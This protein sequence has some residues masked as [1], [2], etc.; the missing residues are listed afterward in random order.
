M[1]DFDYGRFCDRLTATGRRRRPRAYGKTD[2]GRIATPSGPLI[3]FASN[4]YLGLSRHPDVI[5][6]AQEFASRWGT[7]AAASRLVCGTL[8]IHEAIEEKVARGKGAEAALVFASGYQANVSV[9][10][11]LLDA[12][13]LGGEPLVLSDRLNHASIHDGCRLAGAREVRYRHNDLAHLDELLRTH[14]RADQPCFI[15]SETVFSMDGDRADV[16]GL[17]ELAARVDAFLYLDEAHATGVL[18]RDGFGLSTEIPGAAQ[19]VMGTFSKALGSF[20][21][22]VACS[23]E[24]RDYLVNRCGGFIYSTALPPPVVGAIDAALDLLPGLEDARA[25][26]QAAAA[27]VREA[28]RAQGLD[29]G[30]SSTQIVPVIVGAENAALDLARGL[31]QE[32]MLAVAIRPPTVPPGTSRVR[33]SITAAHDEADIARLTESVPRIAAAVAAGAREAAV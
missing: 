6:R 10:A 16:A 22:Y 19:L 14:R 32:G 26:L 15:L 8:D 17:A 20:G 4:D 27:Q 23:Q 7:G 9:L 13:V 3:N 5:R 2:A 31:E 12:K 33:F 24:I 21:A 28:F 11:A 30:A 29:C 25:K 18:G 1:P